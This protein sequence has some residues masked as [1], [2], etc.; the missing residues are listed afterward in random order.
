MGAKTYVNSTTH[1][2]VQVIWECSDCKE[3][4]GVDANLQITYQTVE[5]SL[6][7]STGAIEKNKR[8]NEEYWPDTAL[9]IINDP[10][11]NI[12]LLR[13]GLFC[14]EECKC[15]KCNHKEVWAKLDTFIICGRASFFRHFRFYGINIFSS[16]CFLVDRGYCYKN[17]M[18]CCVDFIGFNSCFYVYYR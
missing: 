5:H 1:I 10:I 8:E 14:A 11:E 2:P 17:S 7:A 15:K 13:K 16:Y 18:D 4:N 12:F 9:K 6:G 3:V